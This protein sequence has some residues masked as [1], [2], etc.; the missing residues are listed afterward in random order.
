[1]EFVLTIAAPQRGGLTGAIVAEAAGALNGLGAETATADWLSEEEAADI[2]FQGTD[3]ATAEAALRDVLS[4]R[5]LDLIAQ[6]AA[7]RRKRLML[8]DMDATIVTSETLD[9]LAAHAGVKDK[10]SAITARAMN[11]ELDFAG[12]VKERV[13]M[14]AGL[15]EAMLDETY[16]EIE[17][18][19]G[20]ETLVKTMRADG[21]HCV[22]VSGGFK[23]F[24]S[25]VAES[26]G[27]HEDHANQ[28]T[29]VD[30]RLT[31]KVVEP[32]QGKDAKLQTLLRLTR[33]LELAPSDTLAVGDGANDLPMIEAAGLGIAFH[34]KPLVA[35]AARARVDHGDLTALLFF[36]GYRRTEFSL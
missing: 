10:I 17:L 2:A 31:G 12:A 7:G 15:S 26:C 1:M 9:E 32:I 30:G 21:A 23:Y 29:I 25:R 28:F 13:G 36:Q 33:E 18:T 22:L 8:A 4:D 20:A 11:G 24:T 27:F 6:P 19:G 14:L 34:G 5:P 35:A 16:R 3:P